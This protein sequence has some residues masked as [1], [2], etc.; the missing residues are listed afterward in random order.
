[1][2]KRRLR[3]SVTELVSEV[4][5]EVVSDL[6]PQLVSSVGTRGLHKKLEREG[7]N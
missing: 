3:D 1:M 7:G 6:V 5:R 2:R 4:V